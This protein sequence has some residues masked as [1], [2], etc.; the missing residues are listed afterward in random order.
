MKKKYWLFTITAIIMLVLAACGKDT[1][2]SNE[3]NKSNA[4]EETKEE[5]ADTKDSETRTITYLGKEYEVAKNVD[6]IVITGAMEA[7]EDAVALEVEPVGAITVGGEFP[8]IYSSVMKNTESIGEKQQPNFEKILGLK[9]DIILGSTKFPDEVVQKLEKIAPTILVSHISSDWEDNLHL[10]GELAGKTD[11]ADQV[12]ADYKANIKNFNH[13]K[14][15]GKKVAALRIRGGQIFV[16]PE[17]I[18]FNAVLYKELGLEVPDEVKQAKAQEAISVEQLAKMNPD[19]IFMQIQE[20]EKQENNYVFEEM[21]KDPIVQ[22]IGAFKHD[23][24]FVNIVDP[25][26]EG[27]PVYSRMLFLEQLQEKLKQ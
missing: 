25:L 16:Y 21:K 27:G 17:D 20:S 23:Q 9:P 18:F 24:V 1:D 7:M 13:D 15:D 3:M 22:N 2:S 5:Q 4:K 11:K 12:L 8:E 10:M 19:Y 6:R 26:L 14:L